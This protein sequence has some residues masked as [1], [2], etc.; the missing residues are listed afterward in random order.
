MKAGPYCGFDLPQIISIKRNEQKNCDKFYWGYGGVFCHPKRVLPFV[1][2]ALSEGKK[3][4]LLFSIT[5]SNFMSPIGR[6]EKFSLDKNNWENLPRD[7]LLVGNQYALVAQNLQEAN[8]DLDLSNYDS[9]LGDQPGKALSEYIRYRI[10]KSCA[11]YSPKASLNPK[12][13]KIAYISELVPPY[14]IYVK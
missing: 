1:D 14:C 3:V 11:I 4:W 2:K 7:V 10:D 13:V 8:W 9:M 5:K 6:V 12:S